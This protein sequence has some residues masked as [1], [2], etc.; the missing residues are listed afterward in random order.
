MDDRV[1]VTGRGRDLVIVIDRLVLALA[2][3]WLLVV[4]VFLGL[5]LGL[6]VLAPVLM[7]TGFAGPG[8]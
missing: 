6:A 1:V 2:R 3:H 7:A 5:Y 4:N 8:R